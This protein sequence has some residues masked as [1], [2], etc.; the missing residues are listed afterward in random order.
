MLVYKVYFFKSKLTL[1]N[2]DSPRVA[3]RLPWTNSRAAAL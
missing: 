1:D 2:A 3:F